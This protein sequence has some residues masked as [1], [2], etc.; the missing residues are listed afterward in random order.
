MESQIE[1]KINRLEEKCM[2]E[3]TKTN[4]D[5]LDE[6]DVGIEEKESENSRIPKDVKSNEISK[7]T[8]KETKKEFIE[9]IISKHFPGNDLEGFENARKK[10]MEDLLCQKKEK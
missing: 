10:S 2:E 3:E 8:S 4:S 6:N 1:Q 9:K 5:T 7:N